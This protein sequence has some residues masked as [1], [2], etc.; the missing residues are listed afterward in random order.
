MEGN[1]SSTLIRAGV[2][3][4]MSLQ[5]PETQKHYY[6]NRKWESLCSRSRGG[7]SVY[8]WVNLKWSNCQLIC[9][10][11]QPAT[12]PL[13]SSN[14]P[15]KCEIVFSPQCS[16]RPLQIYEF[17]SL[18]RLQRFGNNQVETAWCLH[19]RHSKEETSTGKRCRSQSALW[20]ASMR[21]NY[22]KTHNYE[23][24]RWTSFAFS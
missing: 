13:F 9:I 10:Q 14:I 11:S 17:C 21:C 1:R 16:N 15:D 18:G 5:S 8:V 19:L 7:L 22:I 3:L 24:K 2:L 23:I 20:I 4:K 6:F 12:P